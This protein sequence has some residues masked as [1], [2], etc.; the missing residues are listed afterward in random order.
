MRRTVAAAVDAG[1]AIGAHVGLPDL[2]GFGRRS[3]A[4]TAQ[5][6][7]DIAV[8]QI[9]ALA[10][11]ARTQGAS[12]THMKPH[13][14]LYHMA[15]NDPE[16]A[17]ALARAVHDVDPGL[18]L[19]GMS[20]GRLLEAGKGIGLNVTHEVFADRRYQA[21][22]RLVSRQQQGA[23]IEDPQQAASQAIDLA[24]HGTV[25]TRDGQT[26]ERTADSICVH[27]DRA[28]AENFART[29]HKELRQAGIELRHP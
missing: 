2:V 4:I 22:G 16:L 5:Q 18:R 25:R 6:A 27:G 20:G 13:G 23:V 24:L 19:V 1:V 11:V 8:V 28:D 21:D 14:A 10:A 3:M 15:E 29:L 9:G 26:L 12:L 7:Y 17:E